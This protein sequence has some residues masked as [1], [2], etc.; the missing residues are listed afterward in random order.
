MISSVVSVGWDEG[1]A[2]DRFKKDIWYS[3]AQN[4][5]TSG[6]RCPLDLSLLLFYSKIMLACSEKCFF[7][8]D[9]AKQQSSPS[10]NC[11]TGPIKPQ[12]RPMSS[13]RKGILAAT[14][15]LEP[16]QCVLE[17]NGRITPVM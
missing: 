17:A 13:D 16:Q 15:E 5:K 3:L 2:F 7:H 9:Q 4:R 10:Q 11:D 1:D 8:T 6:S 12:Q 14:I